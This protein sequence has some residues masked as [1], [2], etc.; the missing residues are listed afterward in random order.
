V[1][2]FINTKLLIKIRLLHLILRL[3]HAA[4]QLMRRH[5]WNHWIN[6]TRYHCFSRRSRLM[7]ITILQ[8]PQL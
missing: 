2:S 6:T 7:C 5:C 4:T 1:R 3:N 8:H